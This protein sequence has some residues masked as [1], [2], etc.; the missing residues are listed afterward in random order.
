MST[1]KKFVNNQQITISSLLRR[2]NNQTI[3]VFEENKDIPNDFIASI[4]GNIIMGIPLNV[5]GIE[6]VEGRITVI[7]G[8]DDI[9]ALLQFINNDIE[10]NDSFIDELNN[11]T[12]NKL[13]SLTLNRFI[14]QKITISLFSPDTDTDFLQHFFN[15]QFSANEFDK[16]LKK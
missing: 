6:S 15:H 16:I 9:S 13:D 2:H 3:S 1:Q 8:A 10:I 4:V 11:K 14:D 5:V 12:F 7:R